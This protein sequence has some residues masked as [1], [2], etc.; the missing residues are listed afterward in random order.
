MINCCLVAPLD[1]GIMV[2]CEIKHAIIAVFYLPGKTWWAWCRI[3]K[4]NQKLDTDIGE[5]WIKF[6]M[7]KLS[8]EDR[9]I[10]QMQNKI[11]DN[12]SSSHFCQEKCNHHQTTG[13]V[14]ELC[15]MSLLTTL[16]QCENTNIV[17]WAELILQKC[18][19]FG[20]IITL[21]ILP[22]FLHLVSSNSLVNNYDDKSME[23]KWKMILL[24]AERKTE[25]ENTVTSWF[26]SLRTR[27]ASFHLLIF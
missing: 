12:Y 9:Q 10:F 5:L 4:I 14:L 17:S 8:T 2:F 11:S 24:L 21:G 16:C 19:K 26:R 23:Y 25:A 18:M 7:P 3:I 20:K 13:S 1:L 15:G 27:L 22:D 6:Y